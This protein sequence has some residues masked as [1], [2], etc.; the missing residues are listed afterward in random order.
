MSDVIRLDRRSSNPERTP[1]EAKEAVDVFRIVLGAFNPVTGKHEGSHFLSPRLVPKAW[2]Q[3]LTDAGHETKEANVYRH[4]H[5][6]KL[7]LVL[8]FA[9]PFD[10]VNE[11]GEGWAKVRLKVNP[12]TGWVSIHEDSCPR[13][14]QA[15]IEAWLLTCPRCAAG[16]SLDEHPDHDHP[17]A[18]L[19]SRDDGDESPLAYVLSALDQ[20]GR[21][22][23]LVA[24]SKKAPSTVE[25]VKKWLAALVKEDGSALVPPSLGQSATW[26]LVKH[27]PDSPSQALVRKAQAERKAEAAGTV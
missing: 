23:D 14:T 9:C 8:Q 15:Q 24:D 18:F 27:L 6:Q 11:A 2:A 26:D 13:C 25:S 22:E 1:S 3:G 5:W 10:H 20:F 17:N 4:G 19:F 12:Y 21:G 16:D 7:P